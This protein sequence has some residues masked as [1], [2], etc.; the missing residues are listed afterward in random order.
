MDMRFGESWGLS[1]HDSSKQQLQRCIF[2]RYSMYI[3]LYHQLSIRMGPTDAQP[4][5]DFFSGLIIL[6]QWIAHALGEAKTMSVSCD[7]IF[8]SGSKSPTNL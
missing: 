8:P 6:L 4:Q 2:I 7:F 3:C 1:G 5:P